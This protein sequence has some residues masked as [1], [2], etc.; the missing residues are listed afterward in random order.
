[1]HINEKK[2]ADAISKCMEMGEERFAIFPFG[3]WGK[4]TK[5]ILN[6]DFNI[7]EIARIDNK[8]AES[9][10]DILSFE[11]AAKM[12]TFTILF[13][14]DR[15]EIREELLKQTTAKENIRVCDIAAMS[16]QPDIWFSFHSDALHI[17]ECDEQQRKAI[18]EKTKRAWKK[19]GEADPYWSVLTHNDYRMSNIDTEKI[20]KFYASGK[21]ECR[22]IIQTLKRIGRIDDAAEASELE[23]TEIG[24]GVGRITK[25]LAEY[26]KQV[27]AFDISSGNMQIAEKM[28]IQE[29]VDFSLI[30]SME[31][32]EKLPKADVVYSVMVLQHNCPPVIEYMLDNMLASLKQDGICMFQVPTYRSYYRFEYNEYMENCKE[33]MEMHLL[34]QKKIFEIAMKQHCIPLEVYQDTKTGAYDCSTTF[35]FR[36]M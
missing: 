34:P 36:K 19:L 23:I 6:R 8:L 9:V 33:N 35:V 24:C 4:V 31:E 11:E 20:N 5:R 18:F 13:V 29:N 25:S 14:T 32:Y 16:D 22:S 17:D 10:N 26:F 30:Q 27:Y 28:V 2:I 15:E 1:M 12:G 21:S 7:Q 3:T